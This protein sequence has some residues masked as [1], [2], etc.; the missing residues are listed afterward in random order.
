[1]CF[2]NGIWR[3][4]ND[5]AKLV[6]EGCWKIC[7]LVPDIYKIQNLLGMLRRIR[8][9]CCGLDEGCKDWFYL[10]CEAGVPIPDISVVKHIIEN[11]EYV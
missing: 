4:L 10:F 11:V 8:K 7:L 3:F 2:G 1:M 9:S 5:G 6:D